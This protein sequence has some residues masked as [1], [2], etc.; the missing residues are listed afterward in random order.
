M[1]AVYEES[2]DEK[3]HVSNKTGIAGGRRHCIYVIDHQGTPRACLSTEIDY[4][5]RLN[6]RNKDEQAWTMLKTVDKDDIF[7]PIGFTPDDQA[8]YVLSNLNR[9]TI[10]LFEFNPTSHALSEAL[11][12]VPGIDLD[13]GVFAPDRRTLIGV[14]FSA[15]GGGVYYLDGHAAAIQKS[16]QGSFPKNRVWIVNQS[17]D[18]HAIIEVGGDQSPGRYYLYTDATHTLE[19][20]GDR[21][22]WIDPAQAASQRQVKINTRDNLVLRGYLNLPGAREP[23]KLP[24]VVMPTG[25]PDGH[26]PGGWAPVA[27][28]LASRGYAVLRL[29][30]R[31]SSGY[32]RAFYATGQHH[33]PAETRNDVADGIAWAVSEGIADKARVAIF[34]SNFGGYVAL[35]SMAASPDAFRCGISYGGEVNLEHLFSRRV[36]TANY[37]GERTSR[38]IELWERVFE[39]IGTLTPCVRNRRCTTPPKYACRCCWRIRK[40]IPSCRFRT[41]RKCAT[42]SRTAAMWTSCQSPVNRIFLKIR[43]IKSSCTRES[44]LSCKNATRRSEPAPG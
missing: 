22:P 23:H 42:R 17:N 39:I 30:L 21:A 37:Y 7:V 6:F 41:P 35:M 8:L 36:M 29:N 34:G 44:T 12:E 13:R 11:V 25:G 24:L 1:D 43:P 18:G 10:A 28:F 9:D 2:I 19:S 27:Q 20:I 26:D 33:E 15:D 16:L 40:T 31:G 14:H 5:R 4:S 32:G 3:S 38:H